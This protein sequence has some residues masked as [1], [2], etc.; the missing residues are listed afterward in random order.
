MDKVN[1]TPEITGERIKKYLS[2]E[3]L[4]FDGRKPTEFR[5]LEIETGIS[6]NA[7]GSVR[8]KLGKTEVVVGVKMNVGEP[9]PDSPEKGNLMVTSELLPLSSPEYEAGPPK[10]PAIELGRVIDRGIRESKFI[11]FEKL[12]IKEGEKSWTVFI[13]I[14]SINDDGGIMDAAAI[15]AIVALKTAKMPKYDEENDKVLFGEFTDKKLPLSDKVPLSKT[16]YKLGDNFVIDPTKQEEDISDARITIGSSDGVISS[17]QKGGKQSMTI[18][19]IE[20]VLD[21]NEQIEK[22]ITKK[23]EKYIK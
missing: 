21:L 2:E 22:D 11:D 6:K 10:F 12:C 7:E 20:K 17:I 5:D 4:R 18:E 1:K 3:G 9:Y 14:F 19:E 23:I 15:G 16:F 13:D 8:V